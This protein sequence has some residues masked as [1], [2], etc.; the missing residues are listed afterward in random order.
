MSSIFDGKQ[1]SAVA[2]RLQNGGRFREAIERIDRLNRADPNRVT[3][4]GIELGYEF[5][6]S[7]LLFARVVS[8]CKEASEAL[9]IAARSR[10]RFT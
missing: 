1:V 9:L 4:D 6:F 3:R 7:C 5:Y 10:L 2:E 8:F